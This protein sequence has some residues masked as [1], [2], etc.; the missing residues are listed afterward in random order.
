MIEFDYSTH[1][2]HAYQFIK[3][4]ALNRRNNS[5]V[6]QNAYDEYEDWKEDISVN[7]ISWLDYYYLK[8]AFQY[9]SSE[10]M[11]WNEVISITFDVY[12]PSDILSFRLEMVEVAGAEISGTHSVKDNH[13]YSE[14]DTYGPYYYSA[15]FLYQPDIQKYIV[16]EEKNYAC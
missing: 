2:E 16:I 13:Y 9:I 4:I 5:H 3:E 14:C 1:K 11:E 10:E 8:E 6:I 12:S 7:H 15:Y